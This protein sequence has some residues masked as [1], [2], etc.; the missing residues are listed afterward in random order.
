MANKKTPKKQARRRKRSWLI[1]ALEDGK[2]DKFM[3]K[4][5]REF[6]EG[7]ALERHET[8]Y[9]ASHAP[10]ALRDDMLDRHEHCA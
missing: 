10:T 1:V 6:H 2:L 9:V 8:I 3:T 7:S 4:A 5:L